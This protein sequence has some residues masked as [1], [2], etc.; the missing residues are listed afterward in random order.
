[1]NNCK[2]SIDY[3][4][5]K[6]QSNCLLQQLLTSIVNFFAVYLLSSVLGSIR[7]GFVTLTLDYALAYPDNKLDVSAIS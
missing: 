2:R 3:I 5:V 7:S 4:I 6:C 1:M